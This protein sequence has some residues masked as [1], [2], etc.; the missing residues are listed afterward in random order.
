V[1]ETLIQG[2]HEHGGYVPGQ[3]IVIEYRYAE[4]EEMRSA[5]NDLVRLNVD[6]IVAGGT[7]AGDRVA[8]VCSRQVSPLRETLRSE[9]VSASSLIH[10]VGDKAT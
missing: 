3:N 6:V 8:L 7:P 5:A 1:T 2:L 10:A 4:L 9:P